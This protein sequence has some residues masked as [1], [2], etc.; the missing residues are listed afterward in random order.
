M[1]QTYEPD[2]RNS[3][4]EKR[5]L[6]DI[7]EESPSHLK[8]NQ[9]SGERASSEVHLAASNIEVVE[10]EISLDGRGDKGNFLTMASGDESFRPGE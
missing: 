2:K 1:N 4:K 7:D 10:D 5:K 8:E 9:R 3:T 6:S